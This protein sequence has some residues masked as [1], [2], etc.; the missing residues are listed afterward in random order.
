MKIRAC[1]K[2]NLTLYVS[3]RRPD[4]Y[5]ELDGIMQSVSLYD[6][7]FLEKA[8]AVSVSCS[9]ISLCG[10]ENIAQKAAR[11]FFAETGLSGGA[12]ITI[13]KRIPVAAGLGGGST[14]AAA[15]LVGLDRLYSTGISEK[16][17][18]KMAVKLGADVP[19]FIKG[20]TQVAK[21]IGEKLLPI[22]ALTGGY[23]LLAKNGEK[24]STAEMFRILDRQP[25][26]KADNTAAVRACEAGDISTLGKHLGNSFLPLWEEN[27]LFEQMKQLGADGVSLSGSGPTFFALF[28]RQEAARTAYET[29]QKSAAQVFLVRPTD[30]AMEI[31]E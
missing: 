22:N 20:G 28:C 17:L 19:F 2:I 11:L 18:C 30:R 3:G 31:A 8:E 1:A 14:D 24:R 16:H 4:G 15:V 12:D 10:E 7:V 5:H 26:G 13:T 23:I 27:P 25:T 9:D 21:G 29:L 6:D